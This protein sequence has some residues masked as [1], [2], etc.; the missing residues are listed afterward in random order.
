MPAADPAGF[1]PELPGSSRVYDYL[2][3]GL[4]HYQA[5]RDLAAEITKLCSEAAEVARSNREFLGGAV[6]WAGQQGIQFVDLGSGFK[7]SGR[8]TPRPGCTTTRRRPS[9]RSSLGW[10]SSRRAS[11]RRRAGA[12]AGTM[13]PVTPP[14][15]AYVLSAEARGPA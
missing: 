2:T 1:N 10:N 6:T 15:R 4:D 7:R 9:P 13:S 8:P 11:S 14:G 3:G 12:A 5:D